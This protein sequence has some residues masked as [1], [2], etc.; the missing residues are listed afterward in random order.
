MHHIKRFTTGNVGYDGTGVS[1]VFSTE[2]HLLCP[3]KSSRR[4]QPVLHTSTCIVRTVH[5]ASNRE[6]KMNVHDCEKEAE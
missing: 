6:I 3:N 5:I 2:A 4:T 1:R